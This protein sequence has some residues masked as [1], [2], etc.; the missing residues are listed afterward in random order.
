M[1]SSECYSCGH[2]K[3]IVQRYWRHF[4]WTWEVPARLCHGL[5]RWL[6]YYAPS[7]DCGIVLGFLGRQHI[8]N[9]AT[10]DADRDRI[11]VLERQER[12]WMVA[13]G[14][15]GALHPRGNYRQYAPLFPPGQPV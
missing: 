4:G 12:H 7:R 2:G 1:H 3:P 10:A 6:P 8:R 13:H 14:G 5:H 15:W 9:H 11:V